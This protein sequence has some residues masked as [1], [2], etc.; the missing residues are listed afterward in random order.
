MALAIASTYAG[1][2]AAQLEEVLVTATKRAQSVQDIPMS[3]EAVSAEKLAAGGISDFQDLAISI[4]N[5]SVSDNFS[6][7]L[8]TMRGMGSGEDRSFE[9]AVSMFQDGIY[10]PRGRQTRS[11][12]F[13]VDR[14]EVLKGPQAVLFGLNSTAGAIAVHSA[15]N[16]PGDAFEATIT[17]EYELE[18]ESAKTTLI[19][20]GSLGDTLAVRLAYQYAD[21]GGW[22]ENVATGDDSGDSRSDLARLSVVWQPTDVLQITAKHDY[23]DYESEGDTFE[24]Y[25]SLLS[26]TD[27]STINGKQTSEM[28][29]PGSFAGIDSADAMNG[30]GTE[31]E[32]NNTSLDIELDVGEHTFNARLGYTDYTYNLYTAID[33]MGTADKASAFGLGLAVDGSVSEEYDQSSIELRWTSPLGET[34][35]YVGG[36]YYATSNLSMDSATVASV[37]PDSPL[38]AQ[39]EGLG[40]F[41]AQERGAFPMDVD[42]TMKSAYIS[43]T[44]NLADSWRVIGGVRWSDVE[45]DMKVD[46]PCETRIALLTGPEWAPGA[47][48]LGACSPTQVRDGKFDSDNLMP[49]ILVQWDVTGDAMAYAKYGESAKAGGFGHSTSIEELRYDDENVETFEL[50]YKTSL[51]DGSGELNVAI[52]RSEFE[53]LQQKSSVVSNGVVITSIGNAGS[54][55][56][57]GLEIDGR[58]A[59]TDWLI[60]GGSVAWLDAEYDEFTTGPCSTT[61]EV[62]PAGSVEGSC[63]VSGFLMPYTSDVSGHLFADATFDLSGNLE[64]TAGVNL[65]YA[66]DYFTD[67]AMEEVN[68]QD[69][70]TIL[71]ARIGVGATDGRWSVNLIG[72]NLTDEEVVSSSQGFGPYAIGWTKPPR[73]ILLQ[74]TYRFGG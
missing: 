34:L 7:S 16:L 44:W 57:E 50:G 18:L 47:F 60:V 65:S 63:D 4:P 59:V 19:A 73:Q 69:S 9:Q 22:I 68:I 64:L 32:V 74:G 8:I 58:F 66:D 36:L 37:I 10:M 51:F 20:G 72:K 39:T 29:A 12:F 5:F 54:T 15:S 11:P 3:V 23:A 1:S 43:A 28:Y 6:A 31:Q 30:P 13:D 33:G 46:T 38:D 45:K 67:T 40:T 52:F 56:A 48:G 14:I 70:Y 27:D 55:I 61:G 24:I 71:G 41:G 62:R 53:D 49:E 42:G 2:A 21:N 17:Q 26:L 25:N 35:E